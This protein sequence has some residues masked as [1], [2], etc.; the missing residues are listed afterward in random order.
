MST[1]PL[2]KDLGTLCPEFSGKFTTK[3]DLTEIWIFSN[4]HAFAM[5]FE[6]LRWV[7]LCR[8]KKMCSFKM[9]VISHDLISNLKSIY[10]RD[11][12]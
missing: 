9:I 7:C 12:L 2:C 11:C 8:M 1:F 6:W 3:Y 4:D 10:Y 5:T